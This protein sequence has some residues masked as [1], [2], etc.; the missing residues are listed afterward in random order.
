MKHWIGTLLTVATLAAVLPATPASAV[1]PAG[2]LVRMTGLAAGTA[3]GARQAACDFKQRWSWAP[4]KDFRQTGCYY[5]P[6]IVAM[7][8]Q[9]DGDFGP[10]RP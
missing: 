5:T 4:T 6:G 8:M 2:R 1:A 10:P 3:G 7:I 9:I